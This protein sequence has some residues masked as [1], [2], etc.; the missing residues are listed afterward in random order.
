[1]QS[2]YCWG[3]VEL[4]K[5]DRL[6]QV[7]NA[8]IELQRGHIEQLEHAGDDST[9][10]KIVFDSLVVSLACCVEHRQRLHTA[11]TVEGERVSAA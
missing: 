6:V 9:S 7:A 3:A 5:A 1:M 8:L 10:A 4:A 11:I 2:V